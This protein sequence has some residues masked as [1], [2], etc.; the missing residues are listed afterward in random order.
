[1]IEVKQA[2]DGDN[3]DAASQVDDVLVSDELAAVVYFDL[4]ALVF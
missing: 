2:V 4:T 3:V 1:V